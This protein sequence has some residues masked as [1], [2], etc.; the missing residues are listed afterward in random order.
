[1]YYVLSS[2]QFLVD[3]L[4][5]QRGYLHL[6]L[7][8]RFCGLHPYPQQQLRVALDKLRTLYHCEG[9]TEPKARRKIAQI[10]L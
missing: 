2:T 3:C 6:R 7:E 1:M 5:F 8:E 10:K 9:D 4:P